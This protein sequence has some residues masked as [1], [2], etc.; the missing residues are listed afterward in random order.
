MNQKERYSNALES[1]TEQ[2][3][4]DPN[5]IALMLCGSLAYSTVWKKS[6]IDLVMIVRDGSL[7]SEQSYRLDEDGIEINMTVTEVSKFKSNLQKM[8]G[9]DFWHSFYTMGTMVFTKDEALLELLED[10]CN[11]GEDDVRKSFASKIGE[12]LSYMTKAEK[13]ITVFKDP[14]YSQH[15]LQMC[16]G[17]VANMELLVN[18]E[19]PTRESILRAQQLNPD[20]MNEIYVIP[21]TTVMSESDVQHTLKVLD[22]YLM[23][24]MDW[25]S[26]HILRFLSDGDVKTCSH[27]WKNC[28]WVPLE[29]LA[30]KGIIEKVTVSS[31]IFKKSKLTVEEAAYFYITVT[32]TN[33]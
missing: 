14:L 18:N 7:H 6:D 28:G 17:V 30:E 32:S 21:S 31:R 22:D 5:V 8:R 20:L 26:K 29:Y 15:F 33:P 1:F 9:G 4:G 25:W 23:K 16:A 24:H 13:W 2:V 11:L 19:K 12:L 3:K 27:I 10:S